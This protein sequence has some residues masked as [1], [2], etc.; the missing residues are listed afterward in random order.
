LYLY[1]F[2]NL[3][4]DLFRGD[5]YAKAFTP[6]LSALNSY[7]DTHPSINQTIIT[8][9]SLGAGATN[10][11]NDIA[12]NNSVT[13]KNLANLDITKYVTFATP[14]LPSHNTTALNIGFE[15]DWVFKGTI[16]GFSTILF[17]GL[18]PARFFIPDS[19]SSTD[20]LLP[21]RS[22]TT[23]FLLATHRYGEPNF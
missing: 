23:H 4:V 21:T 8:G 11:V 22:K 15:N 2:Q 3:Y 6:L 18:V 9:H 5:K 1:Q 16:H 12:L 7:I 13:F 20:N 19:I 17:S 14:V 10:Q